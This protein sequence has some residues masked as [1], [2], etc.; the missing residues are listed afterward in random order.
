MPVSVR[1]A[2]I[3]G[4]GAASASVWSDAGQVAASASEWRIVGSLR[5][6]RYGGRLNARRDHAPGRTLLT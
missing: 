5:A 3:V 1:F 6:R 2:R 4:E